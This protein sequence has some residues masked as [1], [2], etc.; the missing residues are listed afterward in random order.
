MEKNCFKN[1]MGTKIMSTQNIKVQFSPSHMTTFH[2]NTLQHR[3]RREE[4][5]E[6]IEKAF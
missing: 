1:F 3:E 2:P 6:F 4:R 5:K